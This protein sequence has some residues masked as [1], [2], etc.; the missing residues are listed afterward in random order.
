MF[1]GCPQPRFVNKA[2]VL[3]AGDQGRGGAT[4]QY[5]NSKESIATLKTAFGRN[6]YVPTYLLGKKSLPTTQANSVILGEVSEAIEYA[7]N[8]KH[9]W[10]NGPGALE[11]LKSVL[12]L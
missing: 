8:N 11:W 10:E 6:R 2:P 4:Q 1:H 7:Q 3:Q 9:L 5:P 12:S